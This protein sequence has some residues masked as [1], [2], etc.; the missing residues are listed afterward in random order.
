[1]KLLLSLLFLASGCAAYKTYNQTARGKVK[2]RGGVYKDQSW[3]ENLVFKRM[4]WYHGMT[5]YY[6]ALLW[7]ADPSSPFVKWFSPAELEYFTKC[8]SLIVS[9]T[10]SADPSKIS[11]VDFREQMKINGYDDVVINTFSAYL[12]THPQAQ[13]WGFFNYKFMGYCKRAPSRAG[14]PGLIINFPSFSQLEVS[15]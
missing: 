4:S 11:H 14:G 13:D 12:R 7:R 8:E 3:N 1:M 10:Y 2:L 15:L 6:D 9:V 5:L